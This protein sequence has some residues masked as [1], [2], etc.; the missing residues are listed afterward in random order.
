MCVNYFLLFA[1]T[2]L[3][4]IRPAQANHYTLT[5]AICPQK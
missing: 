3:L 2:Q 5:E 4:S 1:P